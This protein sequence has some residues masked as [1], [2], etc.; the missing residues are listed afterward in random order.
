MNFNFNA[1][2]IAYGV[3]HKQFEKPNLTLR[4]ALGTREKDENN[5]VVYEIIASIDDMTC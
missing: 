5:E 2:K 4:V 3:G 1:N